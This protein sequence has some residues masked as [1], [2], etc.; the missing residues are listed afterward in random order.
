MAYCTLAQ[1]KNYLGITADTDDVLLAAL[2]DRAQAAIDIYCGRKFEATS[3]TRY[4][5]MDAVDGDYLRLDDDLISITTLTNGDDSSTV[6][7]SAYYWLWPQNDGPP[8][9]SIRLKDNQTTHDWERDD[10]YFIS[11]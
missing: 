10:G 7:T 2:I 9:H 5:E 1:V 8:Y 11:H 3:G 6:I 4:Y